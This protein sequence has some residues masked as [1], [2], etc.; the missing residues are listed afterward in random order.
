MK[1]RPVLELYVTRGCSAC[2]RAERTLRHC[3]SIRQ[4]ADLVVIDMGADG[5]TRPL[6]VVGGPT[7]VFEGAVV[8]LGTPDCAELADRLETLIGSRG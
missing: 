4:L 5:V 6:G 8:A 1:K 2:R 7:T 3:E